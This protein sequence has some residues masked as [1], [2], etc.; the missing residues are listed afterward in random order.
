MK[1]KYF[2][3]LAEVIT[4]NAD[5]VIR[6]SFNATLSGEDKDGMFDQNIYFGTVNGEY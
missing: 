2:G 6:T 1:K 3:L 5:D 4:F